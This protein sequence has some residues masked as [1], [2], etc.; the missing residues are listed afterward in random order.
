MKKSLFAVAVILIVA[1]CAAAF[2]GCTTDPYDYHIDGAE[3][4]KVATNA[5]F[6]PFEYMENDKIVGFDIAL[7]KLICKRIGVNVV[8]E[9]MEFESALLAV[10]AGTH[11]IA[12][13]GITK[14]AERDEMMDFSD[15]YFTAAQVVVVKS[16]N[17]EYDGVSDADALVE[18]LTGKKINVAFGQI[19]QFFAEGN[20]N[21]DYPGIKDAQVVKQ[22]SVNTAILATDSTSVTIC[23]DTVAQTIVANTNGQYKI[24]SN[25]AGTIKLTDEKYAIGVKNGNTELVSKINEALKAFQADGTIERLKEEF[26]YLK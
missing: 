8:V 15:D 17:T 20:E 18:A 22:S 4:L 9:S 12:I 6:A 5:E 16:D 3:T 25:A 10:Q 13:A 19:A 21:F 7:I 24:V 26:I 23:D 2:V 14:N 1:I 11:D